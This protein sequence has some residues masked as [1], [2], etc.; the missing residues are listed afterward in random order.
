MDV[1]A[2]LGKRFT[3]FFS[4]I[5]KFLEELPGH[6]E[7][8]LFW[9]SAEP[10]ESTTVDERRELSAP[11]SEGVTDWRHT[12]ADMEVLSDSAHKHVLDVVQR[13]YDL[14]LLANGSHSICDFIGIFRQHQVGNFTCVEQVI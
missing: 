10:I 12:Q 1:T 3:D 6:E 8:S 11:D 7:K 5:W 13:I 14:L 4:D 9:P 2:H